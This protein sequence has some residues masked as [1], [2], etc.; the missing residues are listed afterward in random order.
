MCS[1]RDRSPPRTVSSMTPA[2][3][4]K[5]HNINGVFTQPGPIASFRCNARIH[6]LSELERT[7]L[8][9]RVVAG[10]ASEPKP[11]EGEKLGSSQ[12]LIYAKPPPEW[13]DRLVADLEARKQVFDIDQPGNARVH[14]IDDREFPEVT[15]VEMAGAPAGRNR[16]KR[17]AMEAERRRR[18][19]KRRGD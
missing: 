9:S 11:S 4:P 18:E 15:V 17:R 1:G 12:N 19:Q 3:S 16:R 13:T 2:D 8:A 14:A 7:P 5:N 10:I 6:R